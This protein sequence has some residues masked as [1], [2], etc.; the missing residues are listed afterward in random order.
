MKLTI[1]SMILFV[2]ACAAGVHGQDQPSTPPA[3]FSDAAATVQQQL[4]ASL[5][6]L[7]ELRTR[8]AD[9]TIPLSQ[10]LNDLESEL[11]EVRQA[12]QNTTRMLDR[13]TL[14]MTTM[15]SEIKAR[16]EQH[17]YLSNLLADYI[18]NLESRLHIAELQV[19]RELIAAAQTES[20]DLSEDELFARQVALVA[21]SLDRMHALLG[22]MRFE[23]NAVVGADRLVRRGTFLLVGPSALFVS[24]GGDAIGTVEQQIG[25]LE[26]SVVAF[27]M[28]SDAAAAKQVVLATGTTYPLDPTLG[29]AHV[30]ATTK[31]TFWEH[32]QKG[33]PV[34]VP[35]FALAG[36]AFLV[37]C[38]KWLFMLFVRKPSRQR[39]R[40]VLDAVARGDKDGALQAVKYVRG[41]GGTMLKAGVEHIDEPR[42]LIEEVMYEQVLATRLKLQRLL[43]FIAISAA[44]APLLGLLGTVTGIINTFKLITVFGTGDVKMLSGGISE[45]LITT[46]FGLIV[47]IPSLLLHAFLSRKAKGIVD[48]ME[49]TAV[50]YVNQVSKS[51]FG[52]RERAA[53][54]AMQKVAAAPPAMPRPQ[55]T[56][57]QV[58]EA[59]AEIVGL[60]KKDAYDRKP[61]TAAPHEQYEVVGA[62]RG[63]QERE[64]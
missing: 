62:S 22:G 42:D 38:F 1:A 44:A 37:V 51:P 52:R 13:R 30:I 35:I 8:I 7:A 9:E 56:T 45:A 4:E 46:E 58:R 21:A 31:D 2:L 15:T 25:S 40:N 57:E 50:A 60:T 24:A 14:D 59:L 41:P 55:A 11:I 39:V 28:P 19:Y 3:T 23:G 49:K 16:R 32:V 53:E 27:E 26:P 36:A 12:Y 33:G 47:A 29:N 34:M 18:R 10:K 54:A 5:A 20:S 6:E 17:A 43:P 48:H 61:A 64:D 63:A